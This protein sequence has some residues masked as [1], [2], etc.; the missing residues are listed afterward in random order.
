MTRKIFMVFLGLTVLTCGAAASLSAAE[1]KTLKEVVVEAA[2]IRDM[3]E[4]SVK[5]SNA[6]GTL[7]SNPVDILSGFSGIDVRQRSF[8]T[9]Q[10]SM[11]KLRGFDESRSLILLGD[12]P[13]NGTGVMGGY[14]V[15][16]SMI[17]LE[18]IGKVEVLRG[19]A[20]AEYGDTLGGVIRLIPKKLERGLHVSMQG[21]AQ[22]Y[23][24]YQE[25]GR[26]SF[27][28]DR[29]GFLFSVDHLE[30]DGFLRNSEVDRDAFSSAFSLYLP[31]GGKVAFH[32]NY[33][34]G[35]YHFPM[36]NRPDSIFYDPSWPESDGTYLAGP[37]LFFKADLP[38]TSPAY[39]PAKTWGEG[40]M[41]N[42]KRL[43]GDAEFKKMLFGTDVQADIYFNSEDRKERFYAADTGGCIIK[44]KT[45]PD[46]SWGW[47]VKGSRALGAHRLKAG[48]EGSHLGYGS[49]TYTFIDP[50][51]L[52]RI[53]SDGPSRRD[54]I[55]RH[56]AFVQDFWAIGEKLEL[57]GGIRVDH[58]RAAATLYPAMHTP[59]S[60]VKDTVVSPK[61]GIYVYPFN[62]LEIF[63]T[64]GRAARFP[65]APEFYWYFAGYDPA[66]HGHSRKPLTYEDALQYEAGVRFTPLPRLETTLRGYY[67]DV[68]DYIRTIFGYKPSRVVYNID[69]VKFLGVE[70]ELSY[71]FTKHVSCFA[72]VTYEKTKKKGDILDNSNRLTDELPEIPEWKF[73]LGIQYARKGGM[74]LKATYRWVDDRAIP[75]NSATFKPL[76]S[77]CPYGACALG[78][79][80]AYGVVDVY[81][82]YPF[83][84]KKI[85]GYLIAGCNNL[86]DERYEETYGYP[87]PHQI[88]FAGLKFNY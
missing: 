9:P 47:Q 54:Q 65:T 7:M 27:R 15:D 48:I 33:T 1:P 43:I 23:D 69:Q 86:F 49:L 84:K 28:N 20:T 17:S 70:G 52:V 34:D 55:K 61:F 82:R 36:Y 51:Y 66:A 58:Y 32:L 63:S 5:V 16:W 71:R 31:Q 73:N 10:Q 11:I 6:G 26:A 64:V 44:R 19:G 35:D 24:T 72:N 39:D 77:G 37:G 57:Y 53:P 41:Y 74:L 21:G 2:K 38:K 3:R 45:H 12:R 62:G 42:K 40:S 14:Y 8:L 50:A 30:T 22:R 83:L 87:M 46:K 78:K 67:Y 29:F 18:D 56:G 75:V 80:D 79:M 88:W 68:D 13:L 85:K 25:S 81:L 60:E 76:G 59:T 4:S